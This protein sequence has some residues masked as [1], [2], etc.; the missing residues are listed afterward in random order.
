MERQKVRS[1]E[2]EKSGE[3]T[4]LP[5]NARVLLCVLCVAVMMS[6]IVMGCQ[7]KEQTPA[8][9]QK[10]QVITTLFPVYDFTRNVAG[11]KAH[12]ILLLPPG[13]EAHSFEP[14]PGDI[15]KI[16]SAGLLIYTGMYMEPWIENILKGIDNKNLLVVDTSRGITL[17]ESVDDMDDHGHKEKHGHEKLDPH[18]WLDITNAQ[19]MVDNILEGLSR[20]DPANSNYYTKNAEAYKAKLDEIDKKYRDTLST[21]KQKVFIHGGHFAFGYLA[22][23]YGLNYMAAYK[24]S[25]DAEPTPRRITELKKMLKT[26]D[27]KYIYYEE[28]I[29]PR[30]AEVVS[31][32]TGAALLKIHGAHNVSKEEMDKGITFLG[33]M[34]DNLKSLQKG[35]GCP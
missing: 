15:L 3:T 18:I 35:L 8:E 2:G 32:E 28:L 29:T 30:V 23:R 9:L 22:K 34:E 1:W 11:D 24:G 17:R 13:V 12:V 20:K 31:K 27:I 25:P 33:I 10:L 19:K 6:F 21:C 14:K 26:Y 5:F 16:S 4:G 7:K